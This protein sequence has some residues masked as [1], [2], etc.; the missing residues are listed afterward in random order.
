MARN[1]IDNGVVTGRPGKDYVC[2]TLRG[3]KIQIADTIFVTS[4][5]IYNEEIIDKTSYPVAASCGHDKCVCL[6]NLQEGKNI[7]SRQTHES[8]VTSLA[9][10]SADALMVSGDQGGGVKLWDIETGQDTAM[11]G[12]SSASVTAMLSGVDIIGQEKGK[13]H[14]PLVFVGFRDGYVKMWDI[15]STEKPQYELSCPYGLSYMK[16]KQDHILATSFKFESFVKVFDI[17]FLASDCFKRPDL[18]TLQHP[19]N[20]EVCCV[21]WVSG[22]QNLLVTAYNNGDIILWNADKGEQIHCFS[23]HA[24]NVSCVSVLGSTVVSGG[25]DCT[26]R[27]WDLNSLE[28][29][30]THSDHQGP[31]TDFYVDAYRVMTCSR[32]YSIRTYKWCKS[33][34]PVE[35][36]KGTNTL[37]SKYTLLGGSLQRAGNG[38]E[39]VICDY[40][41]CVGMANDVLK[42]YSFQ[43]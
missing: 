6:W 32:D 30:Q 29:V 39:K 31:V 22:M 28:A 19:S 11:Q 14:T 35:S 2:K 33:K 4:N 8:P 18:H 36:T 34:S 13:L 24:G 21:S 9:L 27:L 15:R 10:V 42:A 43:V 25:R 3:H 1:K 40:S 16:L 37:E 23:G 17:R 26:L 12:S 41:T 5:D 38:F 7:W 20:A